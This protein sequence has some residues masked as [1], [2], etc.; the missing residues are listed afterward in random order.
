MPHMTLSLSSHLF[1]V[2]DPSSGS[3]IPKSVTYPYP[4]PWI[5]IG[6]TI[7]TILYFSFLI[8]QFVQRVIKKRKRQKEIQGSYTSRAEWTALAKKIQRSAY[9]KTGSNE[10]SL[11]EDIRWGVTQKN[12]KKSRWFHKEFDLEKEGFQP[13]QVTTSQFKPT[14]AHPIFG[15]FLGKEGL[16][17]PDTRMGGRSF[18]RDNTDRYPII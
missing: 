4:I 16:Q 12:N 18:Q 3:N 6:C 1:S 9:P 14:S 13:Q 8:I 2:H 5:F 17:S 15:A 10:G 11:L 7:L